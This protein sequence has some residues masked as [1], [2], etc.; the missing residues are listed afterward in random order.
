M[1]QNWEIIQELRGRR[2]IPDDHDTR[3]SGPKAPST[4]SCDQGCKDEAGSTMAF[5]FWEAS[6]LGERVHTLD[7]WEERMEDVRREMETMKE[8]LKGKAPTTTDKLI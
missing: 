2:G 8:A 4:E 1:E 6:Q 7:L 5:W 3:R